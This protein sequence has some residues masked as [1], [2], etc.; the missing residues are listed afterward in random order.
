MSPRPSSS[1]GI[2]SSCVTGMNTTCTRT[3]LVF[4]LA[5]RS[6][7]NMPKRVVDEA[8]RPAQI[9]EIIDLRVRRQHPDDTALQHAVEIA[10]PLHAAHIRQGVDGVGFLLC[11]PVGGL[12]RRLLFGR[13]RIGGCLSGTA[14]LRVRRGRLGRRW[15]PEHERLTKEH[16]QRGNRRRTSSPTSLD[17]WI[18]PERDAE[19]RYCHATDRALNVPPTRVM[20]PPL[21]LALRAWRPAYR[22]RTGDAEP[23]VRLQRREAA[24][25][26]HRG[27]SAIPVV[28]ISR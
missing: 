19:P 17:S 5:F 2:R 13:W 10:G 16:A 7:S 22:H 12:S 24:H 11:L 8:A 26:V 18:S 21:K 14:A 23:R 9:D 20:T 27:P 25:A 15:P 6:S 1:A 28:N 4:S 3:F